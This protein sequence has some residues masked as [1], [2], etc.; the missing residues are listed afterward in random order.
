M[1]SKA[2]PQIGQVPGSS[3]TISGCMGQ[4]YWTRVRAAG[5][6][7][8]SAMPHFGQAAGWGELTPGHMGQ[9]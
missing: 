3:R 5:V 8:S 2:M 9:M 4:V 6:A 7:G 1:G